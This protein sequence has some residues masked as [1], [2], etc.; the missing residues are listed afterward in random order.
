MKNTWT[1]QWIDN[2][3]DEIQYAPFSSYRDAM[4]W[5]KNKY[6][7]SHIEPDG[8]EAISMPYCNG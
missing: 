3:H 2:E 4:R 6:D 1:V 7:A 5:I 8:F